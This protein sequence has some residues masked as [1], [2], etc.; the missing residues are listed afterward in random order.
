MK[1]DKMGV[2]YKTATFDTYEIYAGDHQAEAKK[3]CMDY[4]K[5][6][7]TNGESLIL[8]GKSGTGKDHLAISVIKALND[9][10]IEM[11]Q[12]EVLSEVKRIAQMNGKD[13]HKE[14]D[15]ILMVDMFVIFDFGIRITTTDS[16]K[17]LLYYVVNK[18]YNDG[19]SIILTS[20]LFSQQFKDAIDFPGTSR[21][22]DRLFEMSC[23]YKYYMA[24]EWESYRR[25]KK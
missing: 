9:I 7:K 3:M 23:G 14:I 25:L 16:Q 5:A 4:V 13:W 15:A 24:C 19:V 12:F 18:C 17:E 8:M 21:V 2:R 20:N 1:T 6:D 22:A 10:D 11:C